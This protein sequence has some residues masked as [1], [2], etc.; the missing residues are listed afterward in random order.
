MLP[1]HVT[2]PSPCPLAP[3]ARLSPDRIFCF[4]D[5]CRLL[6]VA[7]CQLGCVH[8]P[9]PPHPS[10]T[11]ISLKWLLCFPLLPSFLPERWTSSVHV[12]EAC[13]S[14]LA[15]FCLPTC[16]QHRKSLSENSLFF[17]LFYTNTKFINSEH[18]NPA[19]A[20]HQVRPSNLHWGHVVTAWGCDTTSHRHLPLH[21]ELCQGDT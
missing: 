9:P 5:T 13:E 17:F 3:G 1:H 21:S 10:H 7:G 8:P 11:H 15:S 2:A 4:R 16:Y 14:C 18:E 12:K 19:L 20:G 6:F